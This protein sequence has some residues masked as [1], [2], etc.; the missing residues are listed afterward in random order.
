MMKNFF[1]VFFGMPAFAIAATGTAPKPTMVFT[2]KPSGGHVVTQPLGPNLSRTPQPVTATGTFTANKG[3]FSG[4]QKFKIS[5][6]DPQMAEHAGEYEYKPR[7]TKAETVPVKVVS[8]IPT[9]ALAKSV[10]KALPV[11]GTAMQLKEIGDQLAELVNQGAT[12]ANEKNHFYTPEDGV[13]RVQEGVSWKHNGS[14]YIYKSANEACAAKAKLHP[15]YITH[16]LGPMWGDPLQAECF[17]TYQDT[18]A[19]Y[20]MSLAYVLSKSTQMKI[21]ANENYLDN[22]PEFSPQFSDKLVQA[23]NDPNFPQ[24]DIA[25]HT[26]QTV[27]EVEVLSQPEQITETRTEPNGDTVTTVTNTTVSVVNNNINVSNQTTTTT[28][29]AQGN[30]KPNAPDPDTPTDPENPPPDPDKPPEEPP[31]DLCEK[32][33]DILACKKLEQPEQTEIPKETRKIELVSGPTFGGGSCIPDVMANVNGQSI[34]ILE[35]STPCGWI[36]DYFKPL[37]LLLASISAVFIVMPREV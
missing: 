1:I 2:A 8:K 28:K 20:R 35:T 25:E 3:G 32:N 27:P 12:A 16:D 17:L 13:H 29:D 19:P 15:K 14:E 34:K 37:I 4:G 24:V 21:P 6:V 11:I 7:P 36:T 31:P 9:K 23:L 5:P 33:P 18:F 22:I 10:L 26:A 30:P